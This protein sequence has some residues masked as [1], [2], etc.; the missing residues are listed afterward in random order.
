[1]D[2]LVK[3][4]FMLKHFGRDLRKIK[5]AKTTSR[6]EWRDTIS[7]ER[8]PHMGTESFSLDLRFSWRTRTTW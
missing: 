2:R 8:Q 6:K 7:S 3:Q 5:Q 1:V 4:L